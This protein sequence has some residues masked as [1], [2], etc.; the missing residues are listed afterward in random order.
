MM[1]YSS[2]SQYNGSYSQGYSGHPRHGTKEAGASQV[3]PQHTHGFP[4]PTTGALGNV[5]IRGIKTE[6]YT[7]IL[8]IT[9][10]LAAFAALLLGLV[11]HY[12]VEGGDALSPNLGSGTKDEAGAIYVNFSATI[13]TTV[14]SW[15]STAAPLLLTFVISL[16]SF[17]AA[18]KL[19]QASRSSGG[20]ELPTPFQFSLMLATLEKPGASTLWGLLK[21][22]FSWKSRNSQGPAMGFL[23]IVLCFGL[24]LIFATDTWLHFTTETVAFTQISSLTDIPNAS[25]DLIN[26]TMQQCYNVSH[27]FPLLADSGA[28]TL[29]PAAANTFIYGKLGI[30][31]LS[32]SSTDGE[33]KTYINKDGT[34]FAYLGNPAR[35]DLYNV[36]FSAH[37]WVL[38]SS[39]TPITKDCITEIIGPEA[40]YNCSSIA[41][42]GDI[43]TNSLNQITMQY[44][45][46]ASMREQ[47][48]GNVSVGNPYYYTAIASVNQNTGH[49]RAFEQDSGIA[50]GLHGVTIIAVA[51]NTTV[52]DLE[53]TAINGS[54]TR[55]ITS[56]SNMSMANIMQG[57]QGYTHVA[58]AFLTQSIST[59]A[60]VANSAQEIADSFAN[61][62][63]LAALALGASAM[64]PSRAMEAQFRTQILVAR[65]PLAPLYALVG[66]NLL[67]LTLGLVLAVWAIAT[68]RGDVREIQARLGVVGLVA[69][70]F[71]GEAAGRP[72]KDIEDIFGEKSGL[73]ARKVGI[74]KSPFGGWILGARSY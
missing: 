29:N 51:C 3:G 62:Y 53:Y 58:D 65:V 15:S 73:G 18:R 70:Y 7:A 31:L 44:Y 49:N 47:A 17:P 35:P 63:S 1:S 22:R 8:T 26:G 69:S 52:W 23:S 33:V 48:Q 67:L 21:Y 37:T 40:Q 4:A 32:N 13:L 46:D 50:I 28:C 34:N 45:S 71:E 64:S 61:E 27:P 5:R 56:P 41:F 30:P 38:S 36:D 20:S 11:Y 60:W 68:A 54:I 59:A 72:V 74:F 9:L 10:P 39:C 12:R 66:S 57:T 25:F 55:F 2:L 19:L 24:T 42:D 6:I 43:A 14:A 16:S